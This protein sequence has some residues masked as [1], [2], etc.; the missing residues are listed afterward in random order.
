MNPG[1]RLQAPV[2]TSDHSIGPV[3]PQ[4]SPLTLVE[5]GDYQ[6]PFC[7]LAHTVVRR[8][9]SSFGNDLRFVFRHFPLTEIHPHAFEAAVA[10][11][12]AGRQG[13]YW[14]MHD[15]MFEN[16]ER[17]DTESLLGYASD[18]DLDLERFAENLGSDVLK[19]KVLADITA[20]T[21]S[22]VNGT[23]SFFINGYRYD[24]DWSYESLSR[25]LS[26]ILMRLSGEE[27]EQAAG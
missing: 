1:T 23:P 7:R 4:N 9:F 16:Q 20:G 17:L 27:R 19:E 2:G 18:L 11:E 3:G 22:G 13:K 24:G 6:C 14:E 25:V 12:A 8:L 5:Y 26:T 10:A 15:L 21:R